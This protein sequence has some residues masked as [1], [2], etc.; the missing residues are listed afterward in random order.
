M[1]QLPQFCAVILEIGA[2]ELGVVLAGLAADFDPV[3]HNDFARL[4]DAG[5]RGQHRLSGVG[6]NDQRVDAFGGHGLDVGD[7]L[8]RIAL[9]VGI[10]VAR[11]AGAL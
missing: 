9:P 1:I 7:R 8:L 5:H 11:D 3:G 6:E 10:F 2:D 4:V